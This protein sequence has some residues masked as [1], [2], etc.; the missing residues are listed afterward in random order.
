MPLAHDT[1]IVLILYFHR[2]GRTGSLTLRATA[3][4][5]LQIR[6]IRVIR[7]PHPT[8]LRIPTTL[9]MR[10]SAPLGTPPRRM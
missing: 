7:R 1:D 5:T 4:R 9:P 10:M 6:K 3:T 2:H 8:T